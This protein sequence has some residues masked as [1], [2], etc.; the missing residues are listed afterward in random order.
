MY[1]ILTVI[2]GGFVLFH[3]YIGK[4]TV[5]RQRK[6][7]GFTLGDGEEKVSRLATVCIGYLLAIAGLLSLFGY[8]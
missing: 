8:R 6:L 5:D 7:W 1:I 3:H 2:G 4:S